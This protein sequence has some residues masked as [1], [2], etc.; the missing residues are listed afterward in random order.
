[1]KKIEVS[2]S[3]YLYSLLEEESARRVEEGWMEGATPDRV[4]EESIAFFMGY[5]LVPSFFCL[6][7]R[8]DAFKDRPSSDLEDELREGIGAVEESNREYERGLEA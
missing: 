7:D 2:V 1:M 4:A 3:D 8:M 5:D 6:D